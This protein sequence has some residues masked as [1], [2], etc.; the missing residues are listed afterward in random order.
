[1]ND[2]V[3]KNVSTRPRT[4][5][6]RRM[7]SLEVKAS[8]TMTSACP[9]IPRRCVR[10]DRIDD[11]V[12]GGTKAATTITNG[13]N[14]TNALPASATLRSTN[15]TSN[16]RSHAR[17]RTVRRIQSRSDSIRARAWATG[18]RVDLGSS[19]IGTVPSSAR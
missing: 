10:V 4:P 17:P 7:S 18:R 6:A 16:M 2:V 15:S 11:R 3:K 5:V 13:K 1:M 8:R 12:R 9:P 19:A 14:E